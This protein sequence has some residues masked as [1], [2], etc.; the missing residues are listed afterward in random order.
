[1]TA[2][3]SPRSRSSD[4]KTTSAAS[5]GGSL[6]IGEGGNLLLPHV[7]GPQLIPYSKN[8]GLKRPKLEGRNHYHSFVDARLGKDKT[9]SHFAFAGPLTEATLLG[10]IANRYHGKELKWDT[11]ALKITNNADADKLVKREWRDFA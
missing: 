4:S 11:A 8:K 1:M 10:N 7:G 6:F 9:T 5:G 3:N 2:G